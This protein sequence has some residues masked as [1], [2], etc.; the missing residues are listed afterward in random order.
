[1]KQAQTDLA[2]AQDAEANLDE[3]YY[4]Q[5]YSL[6]AENIS[7]HISVRPNGRFTWV[8]DNPFGE[9]E[10]EHNYVLFSRAIRADGRQYWALH[11]FSM[12]KNETSEVTLEPG[13]FLSTKAIL[14]P[15]L[16]PD[17]IEQ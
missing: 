4:G 17:E 15:N 8:P 6:P 1:L 12:K 9:G 3:K 2:A 7:Y 16:P 10:V 11:E 5:L 14:R 13:G